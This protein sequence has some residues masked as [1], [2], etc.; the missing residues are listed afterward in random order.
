MNSCG[1]EGA[2]DY[3]P[4]CQPGVLDKNRFNSEAVAEHTMASTLTNLLIHVVFSTKGH[5]PIIT[6]KYQGR[7]HAYIGG[8][9]RSHGTQSLSIGG[10]PDHIHLVMKIRSNQA[11][12][13]FVR[14]IK[15]NSS[16]WIN[17]NQF[18][19]NK[20]SWQNGYGGFSVS[21]T[22]PGLHP[23]LYSLPPSEAIK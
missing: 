23:G 18:C 22:T 20:F 16:K 19:R 10:M 12:S 9:I 8:I 14:K 6:D 17:E 11:L 13:E 1:P 3:S 2:N 7:L 4:W 21:L 15:A 5:E